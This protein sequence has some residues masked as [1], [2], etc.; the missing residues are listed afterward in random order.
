MV[1]VPVLALAFLSLV[2]SRA[3]AGR[4]PTGMTVLEESF[5]A[6]G[7]EWSACEDLSRPGGSILL[8]PAGTPTP[9]TVTGGGTPVWQ[10]KTYEPFLQGP[11]SDYYLEMD[12]QTVLGAKW[13]M[14]GQK[15]LTECEATERF[16]PLCEPTWARVERA[17]PIMRYSRGN[18]QARGGGPQEWM[19][20]PYAEESGVRTFVGSRSASVDATFSDHADDCTDNGFPRPQTYVMNLTAIANGEPAI[21]DFITYI[22][23]T[24]MSD[25]LVRLP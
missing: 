24:T 21:Q 5:F 1:H 15:I 4:C 6:E 16:G 20:S 9:A 18:R 23:F 3:R 25:G 11:D 14:L 7:H 13:D 17:L 19:C 12:K 22:N 10:P 8:A 2:V